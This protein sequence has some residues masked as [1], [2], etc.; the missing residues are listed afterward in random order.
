MNSP[1]WDALADWELNSDFDS[2]N[3]GRIQAAFD[4]QHP[5]YLIYKG[6]Q[7]KRI[8]YHFTRMVAAEP[9]KLRLHTKR[10]YLSIAC[11]DSEALEGAFADF[12]LVLG[13]KG[14][15]LRKRLFEQAKTVMKPDVRK[16]I[17]RAINEDNLEGL[18]KLSTKHSVLINGRF[19]P[20]S[21]HG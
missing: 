20:A 10:I 14:A 16:I 7:G 5:R 21:L 9:D 1:I 2:P 6:H 12:L 11:Y 15:T 17:E 3:T 4:A 18:S 8:L 19:Q 13:K